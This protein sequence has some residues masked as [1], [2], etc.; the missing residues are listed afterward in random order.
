MNSVAKV[1]ALAAL[2]VGTACMSKNAVLETRDAGIDSGSGFGGAAGAKTGTGGQGIG[3]RGGNGAVT[4]SAGAGVSG[5]RGGAS[6]AGGTTGTAGSGGAA[7]GNDSGTSQP[8][9]GTIVGQIDGGPLTALPPLPE[10]TNV[11]AAEREDS[12]GIDFDPVEGA[13]DYRVYPLPADG[14]FV[15]NSDGSITV[16]NA[17]YRCAGLR[18]TYDLPTNLNANTPGL[19]TANQYTWS[20]N[21]G[22]NPTLGYV[23][24]TGAPDRVPVYAVA[25]YTRGS[26]IGWRESGFKVY[27][28]DATA[29][30]TLLGQS[31]RDDGIVFYVP[32]TASTSTHTIYTSQT[33][34][35]VA[36]Q[37]WTQYA[38]YYFVAADLAAHAGDSTSPA[39]AFEVLNA[40]ASGA[41][42]L[43]AVLYEPDNRHVELSVGTERFNRA[44]NQGQGPLWHLEWAGLEQ[45]TTLVVE[46]LDSGC[47][48]QGFLSAQHLAAPPHQT[49]FTLDELKSA[50]ATGEVYIN[51]QHDT[52][53]APKA[54]ARSFV[55]VAPQPHNPADW[56]WYQ[57]FDA[58]GS[59]GPLTTQTPC[60]AFGCRFQNALF[61]ISAYSLDDPNNVAVLTFGQFLGQMWVAFDDTG[62]DVTGKVRFTALSKAAI[63]TDPT[64]FLHVTWT[65]NIVGTDRRYPQLILSDQDAPVQ[66]GLGNANSNNIIVQTIQG[67]AMRLETQA[68]HGLINGSPWDV[69]NQAPEHQLISDDPT[70]DSLPRPLEPV[71]EHAGMDR[72]TKFDVYVS[73]QRLYAFL[74]GTRAGCT[75]LPTGFSLTGPV[76]VTFGDVLYHEGAADE[77]VCG[78]ARPYSFMHVHQCTETTRH[79]DDLAFKS[80][81]AAPAWDETSLP[82]GSY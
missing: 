57:G 78:Q 23:Y 15:L 35:I 12:V 64:K 21:V 80:G 36:G 27:T 10:L 51:G 30:S 14:N 73:S 42:P 62:S 59:F 61:D 68:F 45:P 53:V 11:T 16:P 31:W 74:D 41:L 24:P 4:G 20:A 54:I 46:A 25:G 40:D 19:V 32:A 71:F 18:Q 49:F 28:T 47:P 33:A 7:G 69:N 39:P 65:V 60:T 8:D 26:E 58:N 44:A 43:M 5:G 81:L 52:T 34:D 29:R 72:Q 63:D 6:A 9:S 76:S 79:F 38:R 17:I 2:L 75:E 22:A 37:G 3:G 77:Q 13:I 50:S 70:A 67:P 82:C 48:Y 56:D 55:Q 66:E 1:S